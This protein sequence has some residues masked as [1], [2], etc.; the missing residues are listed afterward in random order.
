MRAST[1][2]FRS[3]DLLGLQ[4]A[5]RDIKLTLVNNDKS[6]C[7]IQNICVNVC[8]TESK[9]WCS[10]LLTDVTEY[11]SQFFDSATTLAVDIDQCL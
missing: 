11:L 6:G 9:V 1:E 5:E 3:F 2:G 8:L 7:K 4:L 10:V